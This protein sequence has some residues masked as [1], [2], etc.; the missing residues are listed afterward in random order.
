ML[1]SVAKFLGSEGSRA[2][3]C[4]AMLLALLAVIGVPHA[5]S[6][7][8]TDPGLVIQIIDTA[9]WTPS[10][11]DPG[12]IVYL[13]ERGEFLTC[14]TEVDEMS[15]WAGVNLWYH[16][17]TGVVSS[18]ESTIAFSNEPAGV[19]VEPGGRL[20]WIADDNSDKIWQID[21]G[22]DGIFGTADDFA[23]DLDGL[24]NAGCLDIEDVTYNTLDG[25]LYIGAGADQQICKIGPGLD[26]IFNGAPPTGDDVV[27][28]FDVAVHGILDPEGIVYDPFWDTLVVADRRGQELYELTPNG[29]LLRKIDVNF[30]AGSKP[31]GVAI[32]P[33]STNPSLRNYYVT[34]RRVDNGTDPLEND[35]RIYEI[36]AIP[37]G[38]NAAPVVDAGEA[39]EIEWPLNTA[40]LDGFVND[41]GHPYPPSTVLS[42]WS[43]L[44]GEGTATFDDASLP[45]ATA[46]FSAPGTYELQLVGDDSELQTTDSVIITVSH[47][48]T[49]S[50]ISTGPGNVTM[51]P[52]GGT[53]PAGTSVTLTATPD[54]DSAFTGWSG[55][56]AGAT[57]PESILMDDDKSVTAA[58]ATLFD[59]T[60]SSSGP[61][62]V[63][64]SPPGGT[65]PAGTIVTVTATPD[66]GAVF[67]GFSGDLTGTTSPQQ[68]TV[69][70]DRSVGASFTQHYTL[71][72]AAAGPGSVTLDPPG[73]VYAVGTTVTVTATPDPDSAFLGWSGAATGSTNPESI[74]MDADKAVTGSFATL[75]DVALSSTGPG[76]LALDPPG[77]TYPAGTIVTV[78]ATPDAGAGFEGFGG[79]LAGTLSPQQLTVDGDKSVSGTFSLLLGL[80]ATPSGPGSVTLDPPGGLYLPGTSVTVSA[81][82]DAAAAFTGWG[83]DLTGTTNPES[84]LMDGAKSLTASFV[85]IHDVTVDVTGSGVVTLD[86]PGGSYPL[87]SV[88][89]VTATPDA[90]ATF[91]GFGGDLIGTTTP[92][93]LTVDGDKTVSADFTALFTLDLTVEGNGTVAADPA[94]GP[95]PAGTLVTISATPAGSNSVLDSWSGDATGVANPLEVV[96]DG[97]KAIHGKFRIK[98]SSSAC[99]IGPELVA[100]VPLIAWLHR[101]RRRA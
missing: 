8:V 50:A 54:P 66:A 23:E 36:V 41:D 10:S 100:A 17:N 101:R 99:G 21:L 77:G 78:S 4:A 79:D 19:T 27:T 52:P 93:P 6:A 60:V 5:A 3:K 2:G 83:G 47:N 57:N 95:Y 13:P 64:L 43:Q 26:G 12:G 61:G 18:T 56:L 29:D 33:G 80:T 70:S 48:V 31:S 46:T 97:D 82:P 53:Y 55:D 14:D 67:D 1:R 39:Q 16:D 24:G 28:L 91:N 74:L 90:G 44:S 20:M 94:I 88:V 81:V 89:T 98:K 32:A 73:G 59:V 22:P 15:I 49:L 45:G 75:Y 84:V 30:P 11:P 37:L 96:M 76:S 40:L 38:G 63:E 51:D 68:L 71:S 92:Q 35:G 58:F 72:S 65:Y 86:P 62:T 9:A 42:T 87:G 69:N 7:Q 34:D 85:P 25:H